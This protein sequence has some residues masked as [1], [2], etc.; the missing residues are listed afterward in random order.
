MDFQYDKK[1]CN[2]VPSMK[3]VCLRSGVFPSMNKVKM[4]VDNET[5][6]NIRLQRGL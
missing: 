4:K 5:L 6:A 3:I 1:K 2:P